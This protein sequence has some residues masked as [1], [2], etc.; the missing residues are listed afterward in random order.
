MASKCPECGKNMLLFKE[1]LCSDCREKAGLPLYEIN[2]AEID[3]IVGEKEGA[4]WHKGAI[5]ISWVATPLGFGH[6]TIYVDPET[7]ETCIDSECMSKEFVMNVLAK[8]VEE[9]D[10]IK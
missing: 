7:D 10:E 1:E 2:T 6:I 4:S 3:H 8:L 5:D 9:A